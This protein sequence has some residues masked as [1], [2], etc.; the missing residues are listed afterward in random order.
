MRKLGN[1]TI[2]SC[3][4]QDAGRHSCSLLSVG[5][6]WKM[7]TKELLLLSQNQKLPL[8]VELIQPL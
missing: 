2:T 4:K 1:D 6:V 5:K 3:E 8:Q 7:G